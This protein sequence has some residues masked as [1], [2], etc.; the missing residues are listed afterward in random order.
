LDF[1]VAKIRTPRILYHSRPYID[2][3]TM[4]RLS[5]GKRNRTALRFTGVLLTVL[6]PLA[7]LLAK[8][9]SAGDALAYIS[10]H[11]LPPPRDLFDTPWT[12][13]DFLLNNHVL[14]QR[15]VT[16]NEDHQ[17]AEASA[18]SKALD[19]KLI[20]V[21]YNNNQWFAV[22]PCKN[23]QNCWGARGA[24]NQEKVLAAY[25]PPKAVFFVQ[26]PTADAA[27]NV[28]AAL[29]TVIAHN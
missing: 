4:K 24:F 6:M 14:M 2:G 20:R 29:R 13:C 23:S 10:A 7:H 19:E 9:F 26:C 11:S 3:C 5:I 8:D 17:I 27:G 18:N 1:P 22:I 12:K 21:E 16:P 15:C 28:A 25:G